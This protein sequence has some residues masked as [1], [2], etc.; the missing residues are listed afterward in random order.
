MPAIWCNTPSL[1]AHVAHTM[2]FNMLSLLQCRSHPSRDNPIEFWCNSCKLQNNQSIM[3]QDSKIRSPHNLHWKS[4]WL[5]FTFAHVLRTN[6]ELA[7]VHQ[8]TQLAANKA[9]YFRFR[10]HDFFEQVGKKIVNIP[11][12]RH[13]SFALL[14]V[15]TWNSSYEPVCISP[16]ILQHGGS[17]TKVS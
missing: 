8:F 12:Y 10:L 7:Y 9:D 13:K 3:A 4:Q 15:F 2:P 11:K 1:T 6:F 14:P 5:L 16:I 17:S